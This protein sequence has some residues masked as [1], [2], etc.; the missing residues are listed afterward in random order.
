MPKKTVSD[1]NT[2]IDH[3]VKCLLRTKYTT[4]VV[5][6]STL[7]SKKSNSPTF[8]SKHQTI[9]SSFNDNRN[10]L[11]WSYH[12]AIHHNKQ[13]SNVITDGYSI[14]CSAKDKA[15]MFNSYFASIFQPKFDEN[16]LQDDISFVTN[17]K[18]GT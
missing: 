9:K 18:I 5:I 7:L 4:Y 3:E 1:K 14:A 11:F 17:S 6:A 13:R 12:K 16:N 10:W 8:I 2:M 15:E